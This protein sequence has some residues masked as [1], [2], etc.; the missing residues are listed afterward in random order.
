MGDAAS[1]ERAVPKRFTYGDPRNTAHPEPCLY[2]ALDG[3]RVLQ[4]E[5]D[6]E[7]R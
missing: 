1:R 4:L 3:L 2:C 5:R 6:F 7:L